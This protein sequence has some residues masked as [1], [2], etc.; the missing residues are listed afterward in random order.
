VSN[1]SPAYP[2]A[3]VPYGS[4]GPASAPVWAALVP[5]V[6][7]PDQHARTGFVPPVFGNVENIAALQQYCLGAQGTSGAPVLEFSAI[8]CGVE[9]DGTP[10]FC[11]LVNYKGG[12]HPGKVRLGFGGANISFGGA[13][14]AG[15]SPYSV[16]CNASY[17]FLPTSNNGPSVPDGCFPCGTDDD[18]H[19][20]LYFARDLSSEGMQVGKVSPNYNGRIGYAGAEQQIAPGGYQVMIAASTVSSPPPLASASDGQVPDGAV[21]LGCEADGTPLFGAL[22]GAFFGGSGPWPNNPDVV[23]L[24]KVRIGFGGARIPYNGQEVLTT[25]YSVLLAAGIQNLGWPI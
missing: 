11:A 16:L 12:L 15:Q 19:T 5:E 18:G 2:T 7:P 13:E 3:F 24:G 6:Y 8:A 9:Q 10:L 23:Q 1:G 4:K 21:V 25:S 17:G 22:T 20:P 14:I